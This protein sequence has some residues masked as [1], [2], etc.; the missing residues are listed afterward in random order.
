MTTVDVYVSRADESQF[1]L[2]SGLFGPATTVFHRLV[3]L[4][5]RG[6]VKGTYDVACASGEVPG[7]MLR[8]LLEGVGADAGSGEPVDEKTLTAMILDDYVYNVEAIEF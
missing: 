6:E 8:Q 3:D 7:A 2:H 1:S 5:H 4:I